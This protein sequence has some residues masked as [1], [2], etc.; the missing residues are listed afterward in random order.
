MSANED[1]IKFEALYKDNFAFLSLVSFQITKDKD[2]AKDIVQD[3]FIYFWKKEPA[4]TITSSF[5]SYSSKAIKNLS[6]QYLE[7]TK[8][9]I[10]I[11]KNIFIPDFEEQINFE[12]LEESKI[13]KVMKLLNQLPEARRNIFI[14]HVIDNNSYSE[15]AENQN[16]SINTVKTQMKRSYSFIREKMDACIII[17]IITIFG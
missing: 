2:A 1:L 10:S 14:S 11:E 13:S 8:Q 6:L 3:F 7:K 5:K 17:L 12:K 15:I 9:I 4:I 16:I